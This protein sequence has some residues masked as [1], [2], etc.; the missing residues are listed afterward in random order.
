MY[1]YIIAGLII[2]SAL[3]YIIIKKRWDLLDGILFS[4][5]TILE[6]EFGSGTGQL[7]LATAIERVYPYI[8]IFIRWF[9]SK[10][11]I[12]KLIEEALSKAKMIWEKNENLIK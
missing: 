12:I 10:D 1:I 4:I 2:I 9:I 8:P 7:K 6:K 11:F 3:S 5:V